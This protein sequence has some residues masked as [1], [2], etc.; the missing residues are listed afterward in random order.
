[1]YKDIQTYVKSCEPCQQA[2]RYVHYRKAKLQPLPVGDVFSRVHLDVLGPMPQTK[3]GYKYI[4]LLVDAF[5][6]WCEAVPM[7]TLEAKE[8]AYK[9]YQEF[10]CR[11]G[12]P[13][14]ILTDRGP[15]SCQR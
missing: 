2:K 12:C 15:T 14:S 10:I 13:G 6:G 3:D 8:T 1:M 4:L 11:F 7:K 5:S 9:I